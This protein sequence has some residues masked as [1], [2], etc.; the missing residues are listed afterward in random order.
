MWPAGVVPP[1]AGWSTPIVPVPP[2]RRPIVVLLAAALLGL[3][4]VGGLVHG[5]VGLATVGGTVDRFRAATAQVG[6]DRS[7]VDALISLLRIGAGIGTAVAVVAAVVLGGLAVANLR[8][9]NGARIAT[10]VVCGLG[11]LA[12]CCV[13]AVQ[14]AQWSV[15]LSTGGDGQLS[16]EVAGALSDAYPSWWVPLTVG[17]SITQALGYFV[18]ATL[19]VLPAANAYFRGRTSVSGQ[20]PVPPPPNW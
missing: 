10:W 13:L 17:L 14:V 8:G 4:A 9:A 2:A 18:V 5:L 7:E 16:A 19:L 11:L 12:G 6:G 1:S 20:P 3:M 15:P